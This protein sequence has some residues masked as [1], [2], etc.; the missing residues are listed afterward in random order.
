MYLILVFNSLFWIASAFNNI[1]IAVDKCKKGQWFVRN[2]IV[3]TC[4]SSNARRELKPFACDPNN[5]LVLKTRKRP[6]FLQE[7]YKGNG[8]VYEC[9]VDRHTGS[10]VWRAIACYINQDK[11]APGTFV[12]G[13]YDSVYLCYRDADNIL[14][15]RMR[16][17]VHDHCIAGTGDPNCQQGMLQGIWNSD[18]GMADGIAY[19]SVSNTPLDRSSHSIHTQGPTKPP[20]Y[21]YPKIGPFDLLRSIKGHVNPEEVTLSPE[22]I[23]ESGDPLPEK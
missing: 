13:R 1:P 2:Y 9:A 10:V 19:D 18:F 11:F 17:P 14:R 23:L 15:I 6:I 7:T 21:D 4:L 12:K 22:F 16:K 5:G 3:F 8:F 20:I